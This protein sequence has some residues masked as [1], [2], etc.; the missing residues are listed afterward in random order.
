MGRVVPGEGAWRG[1]SRCL[2]GVRLHRLAAERMP[3]VVFIF[4]LFFSI[5]A[6][7]SS[8]FA[9]LAKIGTN[10]GLLVK[11]KWRYHKLWKSRGYLCS[12]GR[13]ESKG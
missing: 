3:R 5:K 10:V 6:K 7:S 12:P 13:L 2:T 4:H 11:V 9:Q 1:H 8:D